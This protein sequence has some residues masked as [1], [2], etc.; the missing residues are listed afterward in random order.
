MSEEK[1]KGATATRRAT[2][3]LF[4]GLQ[5]GFLSYLAVLFLKIAINTV[6]GHPVVPDGTEIGGFAIGFT[7][8]IVK[9][10]E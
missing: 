8:G 4:G 9:A 6:A 7:C 10:L 1:V 2:N 3:G 5:F